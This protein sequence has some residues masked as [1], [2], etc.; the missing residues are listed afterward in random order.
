MNSFTVKTALAATLALGLIGAAQAQE[1]KLIFATI[2]PAGNAMNAKV[3]IPWAKVV[4]EAG[5]GAVAMDI[6]EGTTLAN[7]GNIRDR[8]MNDVVQVGFSLQDAIGGVYPRSEVG[9]LPGLFEKASIGSTAFWRLYKSGI[10]DAEYGDIVPLAMSPLGQVIPHMAKPLA[11]PDKLDGLKLMV[12]GKVQGEIVTRLGG[13]PLAILWSDIY[14]ALNRHTIDGAI[15]GWSSVRGLKLNEVT[16]YH[17]HYPLGTSVGMIFMAKKK[18]DSLPAASKKAFDAA[19]GEIESRKIGEY[20]DVEADAVRSMIASDAKQTIVTLNA[21]QSAAWKQKIDP[22]LN[23][24]A[25]SRPDGMKVLSTFRE[26]IA[27]VQAGQ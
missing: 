25:A 24:W 1:T 17:V 22:F 9:G 6:R 3:L 14:E 18:Y 4:E 23:E 5:K 26:K 15:T 21:A 27:Q 7:Y 2:S 16:T 8:V 10:M 20:Y 13:T 19:T 11:S 12:G